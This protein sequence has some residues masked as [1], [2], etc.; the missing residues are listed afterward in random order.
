M[1]SVSRETLAA[2]TLVET[3]HV[4]QRRSDGPCTRATAS[5][6][7]G[8]AE[9]KTPLPSTV[10]RETCS[11]NRHAREYTSDP[12]TAPHRVSC[13]G[14]RRPRVKTEGRTTETPQRTPPCR[15]RPN[16]ARSRRTK[17][18]QP[19]RYERRCP[20]ETSRPQSVN[21]A[22]T[23]PIHLGPHFRLATST[24]HADIPRLATHRPRSATTVHRLNPTFRDAANPALAPDTPNAD[25]RAR[26]VA[27]PQD[28]PEPNEAKTAQA[29][30]VR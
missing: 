25:Q 8:I 23:C 10:S 13:T 28:T 4:K 15:C 27:P 19:W 2:A 3:F 1:F 26:T 24:L 30:H 7:T 5:R 29:D 20:P 18:G 9:K 6:N 14:C 11:P 22:T 21:A 12:S 17:T 16:T